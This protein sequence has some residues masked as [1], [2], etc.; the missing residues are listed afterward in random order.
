MEI[1]D[2]IYTESNLFSAEECQRY[3]ELCEGIGFEPA[4]LSIFGGPVR[5]PSVR[6][7]DRVILDNRDLATEIWARV[8]SLVPS[9]L[10]KRVAIGLNER[11]R[12]YR[13]DVG[14][15]FAPHFDGSYRS[16][17][18]AQSLLTFMLYLNDDFSGGETIIT[19]ITVTPE[20][21]KVLVFKYQLVHE[22]V[23]IQGG[24]KYVLRSDVMYM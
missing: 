16:P 17:T 22:S 14:Q 4:S 5:R 8:A 1:A 6:N 19:G 12:F 7:N 10:N 15:R 21:G 20:R 11:F 9:E 24:R 18:G 23:E 2:G 13:Y 3:I